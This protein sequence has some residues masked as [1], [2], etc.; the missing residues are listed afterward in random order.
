MPPLRF[1]RYSYCSGL[2]DEQGRLYL[3]EREPYVFRELPDN[4]FHPVVVGDTLHG[5]AERYFPSFPDA[6]DLWWVIAD[7][8][9]DRILDGTLRLP[10]GTTLIIPSERTVREGVFNPARRAEHTA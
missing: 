8:Q 1:S 4:R 3:S 7:F 2:T 6:A 9:P 5:L 10:T